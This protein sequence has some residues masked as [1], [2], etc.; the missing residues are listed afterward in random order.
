MKFRLSFTQVTIV[1]ILLIVSGFGISSFEQAPKN[2][3]SSEK[4]LC[5]KWMLDKY[6]VFGSDYAPEKEEKGD[7]IHFFPDHTFKGLESGKID[8]GTWRMNTQNNTITLSAKKG[9]HLLEI[10][11]LTEAQLIVVI[12]DAD[13][14][15]AKYLDIVFKAVE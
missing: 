10:K 13:D 3:T 9:Q 6:Q 15:D 5:K 4:L 14:S 1:A 7:Y 8:Q 2:S 12:D 11:S